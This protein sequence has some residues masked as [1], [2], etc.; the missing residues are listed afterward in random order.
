M[1]ALPSTRIDAIYRGTQAAKD[2]GIHYI[3]VAWV[4]TG[5][6][7]LVQREPHVVILSALQLGGRSVGESLLRMVPHHTVRVA[8]YWDDW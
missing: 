8:F 7:Q 2:L 5:L 1:N 4:H 6:A 3:W